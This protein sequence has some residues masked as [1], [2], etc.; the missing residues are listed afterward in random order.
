VRAV[1]E[2]GLK[3]QEYQNALIEL[4]AVGPC[5]AGQMDRKA[6]SEILGIE[7]ALLYRKG[8]LWVPEK[9]VQSVLESED[10]T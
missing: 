6:R 10:D 3:D 4:E 9:L 7:K 8:M 1:K 5:E 2:A